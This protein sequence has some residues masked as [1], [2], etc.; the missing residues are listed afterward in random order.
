MH[1]EIFRIGAISVKAYGLML[2][3]S[4]FVGV[5]LALK[6]AEKF[7][8]PPVKVIDLS[9]VILL[10]A[11]IGSRFFYVIYHLEEFE[12]HWFDIIN[13]FQS[14]GTVGIAGLSMMGGVVLVI[15]SVIA[16]I[17]IWKIPFWRT[18]DVFAPAFVLGLGITRIGCYLNGCCYGTPTDWFWGVT[19]PENCAAGWHYPHTDIH[20]TQLISSIA[21][22]VIFALLIFLER[23]RRFPGF[24][25]YMMLILY[26]AFRFVIDFF[27]YYEPSMVFMSIGN[28]N[29]SNNQ[30]ISFIIIVAAAAGLIYRAKRSNNNSLANVNGSFT[31]TK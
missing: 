18:L 24:T 20:P 3:I 16:A 1:P 22:F 10:A 8:V 11:I 31:S 19:F 26:S 4:F 14:T 2:A 30:F 27:R 9:L 7:N 17:K 25:F 23:K 28:V 13:P 5:F 29:I 15:I 21:G 6:R 12:G